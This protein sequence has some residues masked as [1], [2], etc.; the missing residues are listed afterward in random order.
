MYYVYLI[1]STAFP[2]ERY[3]GLT[4]DLKRR[5]RNRN[6]GESPHTSKFKPWRALSPTSHFLIEQKLKLSSD[7]SSL[8]QVTLLPAIDCGDQIRRLSRSSAD[9]STAFRPR[10]SRVQVAPGHP[11][12]FGRWCAVARNRF[13]KPDRPLRSRVRLLHLPPRTWLNGRVPERHSGGVGSTPAVR[14]NSRAQSRACDR[15]PDE[16][17]L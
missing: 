3:V 16:M 10:R 9:E 14:T 7:I 12:I 8:A 11:V 1:E 5:F 2:G 15:V 4:T 13:R 17:I 6:D